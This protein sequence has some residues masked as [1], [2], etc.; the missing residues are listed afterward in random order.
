[1]GRLSARDQTIIFR[2]LIVLESELIC[3]WLPENIHQRGCRENKYHKSVFNTT[4]C[5][6]SRSLGRNVVLYRVSAVLYGPAARQSATG[7]ISLVLRWQKTKQKRV[8]QMHVL[9]S[10]GAI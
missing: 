2:L 8:V 9:F 4:Q 1:M 5:V 6:G 7:L 10:F 3:D